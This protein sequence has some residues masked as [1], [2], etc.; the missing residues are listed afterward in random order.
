MPSIE[1][2][3]LMHAVLDGEATRDEADD[4]QRRLAASP[5]ARAEFEELQRLFRDLAAVPK[6]HPP[7][8]L[9]ASVTAALPRIPQHGS[10]DDQLS[11]ASRVL[12]ASP[13]DITLRSDGPAQ[14][15]Q[16]P[17]P[18]QRSFPMTQ[19]HPP[20]SAKRKALIGGGIALVAVLIVWQFGFDQATRSEDVAGTIAAAQRYRAP[21]GAADIRLGDQSLAQLMQNDAF[22]KLIRDPEVQAL[23][24]EPG[25]AEAARLMAQNPAMARMMAT[26]AE[27]AKKAL[28]A[29]EMARM[30]E[31]NAE[32]MRTVRHA[33]ELAVQLQASAEAQKLLTQN[34]ELARQVNW[35]AEMAKVAP[36]ADQV[37][38]E[39]AIA[40]NADFAHRYAQHSANLE[41]ALKS[42]ETNKL[43]VQNAELQR[44]MQ[45]NA[46]AMRMAKTYAEVSKLL[47]ERQEFAQLVTMNAEAARFFAM[48]SE[49]AKIMAARPEV[50]RAIAAYPQA[51]LMLM[52]S[53]EAARMLQSPSA[54]QAA[55]AAAAAERSAPDRA[56]K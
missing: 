25:F 43:A 51:A 54:A 15:Q 30:M 48:N 34:R 35:L 2:Q 27:P 29:P 3:R 50:A 45:A 41:R 20:Y 19:P 40:L 49:A 31:Q 39:R 4:L 24:R 42:H 52:N 22:V 13:D 11:A 21:Q 44:F 8:G 23:A 17:V 9:V 47:A 32:A 28:S 55:L 12:R 26:Y 38:A 46:E 18:P 53:P 37:A 6:K 33:A 10:R 7:E 5:A 14:Q 1:L 16:Q 56:L 36:W